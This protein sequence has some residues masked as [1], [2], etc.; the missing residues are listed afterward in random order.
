VGQA[1]GVADQPDWAAWYRE[2]S[3]EEPDYS[4]ILDQLAKTPD[5]RRAILHTY[6]EP[7]ADDIEQQRR[8]PTK[9]HKAIAGLVRRGYVRV[10]ITTNFDRLLENALRDEGI[11][12]TVVASI[13]DLN[14]AV[15]L[16]HASCYL[17]KL[18]GD[19]LDTR[20]RNTAAE[21]EAYPKK[22]SQ[23]LDRVLDEHGLIVCGWSGDWDAG[24]R[25][26]M[27][28][29]PSRR[30]TTYWAT[31]SVLSAEASELAAKRAAVVHSIANADSFF[32]KLFELVTSIETLQR[33]NP[34][35]VEA[36]LASAKRYVAE[37]R[38]RVQLHDLVAQE[39]RETVRILKGPGFEL[40]GQ[41]F[42]S[43]QWSRDRINNYEAA[44]ERLIRLMAVIARW[45]KQPDEIATGVLVE[46]C[47]QDW[48]GAGLKEAIDLQYYP[49]TLTL[50]GM[51]IACVA[52]KNYSLLGSIF[53]RPIQLRH[54][55]EP[56]PA[57]LY[58]ARPNSIS[59]DVWKRFP[60]YERNHTP[61]SDYLL[62]L[63]KPWHADIA[64]GSSRYEADFETF[65]ILMSMA[66]GLVRY[67]PEQ[68]AKAERV[69]IPFGRAT[70]NKDVREA[71][72][73]EAESRGK[74]WPPFKGGLYGSDYD[75]FARL[76]ARSKTFYEQVAA[77][78]W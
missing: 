28:R 9:A 67:T 49:A 36:V 60:A 66:Y 25:S 38:S 63:F 4:K 75:V 61:L 52:A 37:D 69:W 57:V 77:Q 19:Y 31:R 71:L 68:L 26:A 3:K 8:V 72:F 58:I 78:M 47:G 22:I 11:E 5:E 42:G 24:L 29:A 65:E 14:G 16:A 59:P 17:I 10:L 40:A 13:D 6:I 73:A 53:F 30:Y 21:L 54:E 20:I 76:L 46:L 39:L 45:A 41:G 34:L 56:R 62:A 18:N 7:S 51:G 48:Q 43:P 27:L 44:T 23:L 35:S 70:W 74:E 1:K 55:R 32:A 12:P 64:L 15:P 33:P 50:Y 2:N